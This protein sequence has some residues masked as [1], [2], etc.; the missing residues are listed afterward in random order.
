AKIA[1]KYEESYKKEA[2]KFNRTVLAVNL[3]TVTS[4][5]KPQYD[6]FIQEYNAMT[7]EVKK[8]VTQEALDHLNKI[9]QK[10]DKYQ[11]EVDRA[12]AQAV[13][14]LINKL[15]SVK[16]VTLDNEKDVADVE[17]K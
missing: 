15:P 5:F 6:A 13:I 4:E 2:D 1:S 10:I 11:L 17:S 16:D 3:D 9:K 14:D 7:P 12:A 8:Y